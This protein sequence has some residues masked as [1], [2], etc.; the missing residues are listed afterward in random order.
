MEIDK[1]VTA[2][3]TGFGSG[4]GYSRDPDEQSLRQ[5]RRALDSEM[6]DEL[7]TLREK[8][9]NYLQIINDLKTELYDI[10]NENELKDNQ[11]E[12]DLVALRKEFEGYV[13]RSHIALDAAQTV[14]N[15]GFI[16]RNVIYAIVSI[17][18]AIGGI[19]AVSELFKKWLS[20]S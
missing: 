13:S 19:V 8:N 18:A 20:H 11:F 14:A 2:V 10:R 6:R 15:A 3:N 17:T 16:G 12:N 4:G 1:P 5:L 7:K 9:S